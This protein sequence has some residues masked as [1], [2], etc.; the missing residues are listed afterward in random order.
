M[1]RKMGCRVV[2]L[3][4]WEYIWTLGVHITMRA[5]GAPSQRVPMLSEGLQ[6]EIA[7]LFC[8]PLPLLIYASSF[9]F[10]FIQVLDSFISENSSHQVGMCCWVTKK[11]VNSLLTEIAGSQLGWICVPI[12]N[13]AFSW[14]MSHTA[15]RCSLPELLS[16]PYFSGTCWEVTAIR[17]QRKKVFVL[18]KH[19][20]SFI[21]IIRFSYYITVYMNIFNYSDHKED[22][23]SE[24][25]S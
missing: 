10:M 15:K 24:E 4:F 23:L 1:T 9:E 3:I 14:E 13:L 6:P 17:T 5:L 2:H 21:F 12:C 19:E 25:R 16:L 7:Y 8:A 11:F 22:C 18:E 20:A